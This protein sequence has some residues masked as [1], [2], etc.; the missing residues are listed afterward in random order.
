MSRLF[1]RGRTPS[2]ASSRQQTLPFSNDELLPQEDDEAAAAT[3]TGTAAVATQRSIG[4]TS[5]ARSI[6][7]AS[8]LSSS[9]KTPSRSYIHHAAHGFQGMYAPVCFFQSCSH[10]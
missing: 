10:S 1:K 5:R 8:A 3:A 2:D 9:Y 4:H 7:S 6:T